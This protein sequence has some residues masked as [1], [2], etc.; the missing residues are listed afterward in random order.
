VIFGIVEDSF[1]DRDVDAAECAQAAKSV[2]L[3]LNAKK[4]RADF[5]RLDKEQEGGAVSTIMF[6]DFAS[7]LMG[8]LVAQNL[9]KSDSSLLEALP[10]N[11]KEEAREGEDTKETAEEKKKRESTEKAAAK[12]VER[13][14]KQKADEEAKEK[15]K[16]TKEKK[17]AAKKAE[18]GEKKP[19]EVTEAA[20]VMAADEGAQAAGPRADLSK[21]DV[22]QFKPLEKEILK[23]A[24]NKKEMTK[25]WTDLDVNRDG[26]VALS[27]I[28]QTIV[29]MFP[30]LEIEVGLLFLFSLHS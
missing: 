13:A 7:M 9:K 23:I 5:D 26:Q 28:D 2:G 20:D 29:D 1:F 18:G 8:H 16:A 30:L 25:L 11:N 27:E 19:E 21:V 14:A 15:A 4:L 6:E 10:G 12:E 22:S 24:N 3:K 17:K